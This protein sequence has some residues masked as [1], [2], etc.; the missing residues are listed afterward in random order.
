MTTTAC[1]SDLLVLESPGPETVQEL[2]PVALQIIVVEL[3]L[4]T[5]DG[6][7]DIVAE[8]GAMTVTVTIFE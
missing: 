4:D 7:A 1:E 6:L 2:T 5:L 8:P 3:P